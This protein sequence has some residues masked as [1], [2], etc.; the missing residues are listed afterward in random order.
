MNN[1]DIRDAF[2]DEI[3]EIASKDKNVIFISADADAFSLK[4]FNFDLILILETYKLSLKELKS[5]WVL[6]IKLKWSCSFVDVKW[7]IKIKV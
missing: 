3:Y 2:F 1:K 5:F 4:R 7:P 6:E